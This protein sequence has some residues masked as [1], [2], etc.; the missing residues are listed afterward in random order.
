LTNYVDSDQADNEEGMIIGCFL[1]MLSVFFAFF[2]WQLAALFQLTGT[3]VLLFFRF[4]YGRWFR[5]TR[6]DQK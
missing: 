2:A 5:N 6:A 1:P 4:R 3:F